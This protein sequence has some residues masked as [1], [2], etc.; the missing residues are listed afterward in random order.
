VS[1]REAAE[2]GGPA[3]RAN[4]ELEGHAAVEREL[5]RLW[6]TGRLPHAI[7]FAG[8]RGIGKATLA[9]RLARFVLAHEN[10]ATREIEDLAIAP[11]S[12]V[13][14]RVAAG[15]HADLLTV[16]RL[17]DPSRRRPR[18]EITVE[19]AREIAGFLH[20]T[21]AEGGWRIVVVD[22]AEEMNRSAAN[23]L[24]K[25]LEEPPQHSLLLLV[26]HNPGRLLPTIR[27]RCRRVRLSP[28]PT[29]LVTALLQ[30][31]RP[32]LEAGEAG[33]LSGLTRG[34][35]GR[36]LALADGGGLALWRS[37]AELLGEMPRLDIGRLYA[38]VDG[39]V[40]AEAETAYQAV[41]ELLSQALAC[42]AAAGARGAVVAEGSPEGGVLLGHLAAAAD[43]GRWALLR[44]EIDASLASVRE[45][46]LDRRQALIGAFFAIAET[47]R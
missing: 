18:G 35:I 40:G 30:R 7:M 22:A 42:I 10:A 1:G 38:F 13:F 43:P 41:C 16:E 36:A 47:A 17:W 44:Q 21:A 9:F 31:Y 11:E 15:G 39:L 33:C 5:L 27:S 8:S 37:L 26:S 3:P 24:L 6:Q 32:R 46:N 23:A 12:G 20:L 29:P 25:V 28:L 45:L 2:G 34:S 14:R 19:Q 4:S